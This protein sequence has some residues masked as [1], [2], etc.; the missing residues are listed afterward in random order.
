[1]SIIFQ[2]K[3]GEL[4]IDAQNDS[5]PVL[6]AGLGSGLTLPYECAT[7]TCGTCRARVMSGDVFD[8]WPDAPGAQRLKRDRGDILMCQTRARGNCVIR[9]PALV[10]QAEEGA[11]RRFIGRIDELS[12]LT[13]DVIQF[14]VVLNEKATFSAGQ[15]MVVNAPGVS[16]GRAYSM[17]NYEQQTGRL[18]FLIKRKPGGGFSDWLFK[19]AGKDAEIS[20]FGPLGKATFQPETDGDLICIT[21][22]SGIAGIMSILEHATRAKHFPA[23]SGQLYFGA[24]TLA[25][26][27][28]VDKL[29]ALTEMASG[30]LKVTL[31]LSHEAAPSSTHPASEL[32]RLEEGFVHEVAARVLSENSVGLGENAVGFVAGPPPMVDAAIRVLLGQGKLPPNRIRYD[33]FS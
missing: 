27:F 9:V 23:Y 20:L 28:Y 29:A 17:V 8:V 5:E 18:T 1:M 14:D 4:P 2:T 11:P 6:F 26:T 30:G 24:R 32:I 10:T 33:K 7:G 25:D 31:A 22:G 15:F 12:K 3:S 13:S 16:G 19:S 21:G